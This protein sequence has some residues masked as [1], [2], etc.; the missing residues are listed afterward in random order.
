MRDDN[1]ENEKNVDDRQ[2]CE[3]K[4]IKRLRELSNICAD[5]TSCAGGRHN[6]PRPCDLD[7]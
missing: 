4:K 7:L 5:E 1:G 6:M 2:Y 3:Q